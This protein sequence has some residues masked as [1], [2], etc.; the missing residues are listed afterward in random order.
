MKAEAVSGVRPTTVSPC[1]NPAGPGF[2]RGL[3]LRAQLRF[4][5]RHRY[6]RSA[7]KE[8]HHRLRAGRPDDNGRSDGEAP[9]AGADAGVG[10]DCSTERPPCGRHACRASVWKSASPRWNIRG[11]SSRWSWRCTT[12][13]DRRA[14]SSPARWRLTR[15]RKSGRTWAARWEAAST[16]RP[17]PGRSSPPTWERA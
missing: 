7:G 17:M 11:T 2:H 1:R 12:T 13:T 10:Q 6:G 5:H 14:S 9:A 3:R 16:S 4:P 15:R 8:H